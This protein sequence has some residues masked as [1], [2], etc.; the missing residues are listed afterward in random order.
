MGL[1][2]DP[3]E[4]VTEYADEQDASYIVVSPRRRSRTG[5]MLFG[6]VAQSI[7]LNASC[8]VVSTLAAEE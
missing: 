3:A 1:V 7:L 8:P 5:K 6:S 2:G 4:E